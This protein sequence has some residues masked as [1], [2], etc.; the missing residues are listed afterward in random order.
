MFSEEKKFNVN[1]YR[2]RRYK[3]LYKKFIS[4]K[5][6]V[7]YRK[8]L[9]SYAFRKR[10]WQKFQEYIRKISL[11]DRRKNFVAFDHNRFNISTFFKY[12]FKR[13]FANALLVKKRVS[14][15]YGGLKKEQLKRKAS[16]RSSTQFNLFLIENLEKRL[17][18]VLYRSHF[19][20]SVRNARQ[21]IS[22]KQIF[23]NN[24]IVSNKSYTLKKGD[25]I[26]IKT[27]SHNLMVKN[28]KNNHLWP[29]PPKYLQINYKTFQIVFQGDFKI[30]LA[31]HFPFWLD[32]NTK[33]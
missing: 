26:R 13:K 32:L 19:A 28:I 11:G 7:Q 5:K 14:L 31:T 18:T 1:L 2:K 23:V 15:F 9:V 24:A 21:I 30:N 20:A 17:D 12:V 3:P 6:N 16:K 25:L 10:K 22:H 33:L 27:K 4:L 29:I 8:K